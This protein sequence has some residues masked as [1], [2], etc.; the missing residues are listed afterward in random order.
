MWKPSWEI[1]DPSKQHDNLNAK[2]RT[3]RKLM[4][5]K[6]ISLFFELII[7]QIRSLWLPKSCLE[8]RWVGLSM[9]TS[10]SSS[11]H[12]VAGFQSMCTSM[13]SRTVEEFELLHQLMSD[14]YSMF[15]QLFNSFSF[16]NIFSQF[17]STESSYRPPAFYCS[18][19]IK[20]VT[21]GFL[22]HFNSSPTLYYITRAVAR[23]IQP[24]SPLT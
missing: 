16:L 4:M 23:L 15:M 24:C 19:M 21:G 13:W 7:M 22:V 1:S 6:S 3:R 9:K 10:C 17:F 20:P 14:L 8:T 5:P 2:Q 18:R 11:C 12:P